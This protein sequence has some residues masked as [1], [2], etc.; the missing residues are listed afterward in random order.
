MHQI[1]LKKTGE[2]APVPP[3]YFTTY[4]AQCIKYTIIKVHR[5]AYFFPG[6]HVPPSTNHDFHCIALCQEKYPLTQILH[7][8]MYYIDLIST[9]IM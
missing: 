5:I 9:L 4:D 1:F 6:N 7:T 8:P 2:Q 3:K